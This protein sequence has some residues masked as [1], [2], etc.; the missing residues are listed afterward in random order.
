MLMIKKMD[1]LLY[2]CLLLQ[3]PLLTALCTDTTISFKF[4]CIG[5]SVDVFENIISTSFKEEITLY[6]TYAGKEETIAVWVM[7]NFSNKEIIHESH[8]QKV[9]LEN[10]TILLQ[11]FG[12]SDEATYVMLYKDLSKRR[13]VQL[14]AIH[15]P[16]LSCKLF[17]KH[18]EN[19]RIASLDNPE[20]CG[21]PVASVRWMEYPANSFKN[22]TTIEILP[23]K[24]AGR[25]SACIEGKVL[26][27]MKNAS[28]WD[29]CENFTLE[30]SSENNSPTI[31]DI[32]Q[33]KTT[34]YWIAVIVVIVSVVLGIVS[35]ILIIL[36]W[37]DIGIRLKTII[38]GRNEQT[39]GEQRQLQDVARQHNGAPGT[40]DDESVHLL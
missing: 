30:S 17:I 35:T 15:P 12:L 18:K 8:K 31:S 1:K 25:Y 20:N 11:D 7:Q 5:D 6:K 22:K 38:C 14:C 4:V 26:T 29:K 16:T 21:K 2:Y 9:S 23:G 37:K 36:L 3:V 19:F 13:E 33:L 10:G 27:C 28:E 34:N 24:E 39:R 40:E 32:L